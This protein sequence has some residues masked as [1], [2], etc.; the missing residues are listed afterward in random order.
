[1]ERLSHCFVTERK[2]HW[3]VCVAFKAMNHKLA[4]TFDNSGAPGRFVAKIK[5][6]KPM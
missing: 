5:R 3:E 2:H 1:M 4:V 6:F